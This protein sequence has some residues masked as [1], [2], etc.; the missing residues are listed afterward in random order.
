MS[1]AIQ[2]LAGIGFFC[3][4]SCRQVTADSQ[5]QTEPLAIA[6]RSL[7]EQSANWKNFRL[8]FSNV[9]TDVKTGFKEQELCEW[10]IDKDG[11]EKL[12]VETVKSDWNENRPPLP[13]HQ[14]SAFNNQFATTFDSQGAGSGVIGS[15]SPG[16]LNN[17]FPPKIFMYVCGVNLGLPVDLAEYLSEHSK[18]IRSVTTD[19]NG[20]VTVV[21]ADC[22]SPEVILKFVL[23]PKFG[24]Q[25]ILYERSDEDGL[26]SRYE[27][28]D[29]VRRD[30][31]SG[32]VWFPSRG[33]WLGVDP[34]TR[35]FDMEI[36]YEVETVQMN[37]LLDS[38]DFVLTYPPGALIHNLDT[39]LGFYI[40]SQTAPGDAPKF[41]GKTMSLADFDEQN[42]Q[43]TQSGKQ[44]AMNSG[45]WW[46][47][48]INAF[49]VCVVIAWWMHSNRRRSLN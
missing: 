31:P 44:V 19:T 30:G 15:S 2:V 27:I 9:S 17:S 18:L 12:L 48:F 45:K 10:L 37:K 24:Y 40:R 4:V 23:E 49:V 20:R 46:I 34:E 41:E 3:F 14:N 25:M 47:L 32:P 43:R 6:T 13:W 29:W 16:S 38:T 33:K 8:K 35:K 36:S 42:K 26:R 1:T 5:M 11:R 39:N 21:G 22:F 28:D 7:V